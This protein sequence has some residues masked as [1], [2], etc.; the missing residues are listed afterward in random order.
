MR[1][2]DSPDPWALRSPEGFSPNDRSFAHPD[3]DDTS[4]PRGMVLRGQQRAI[5]C[6]ATRA[7]TWRPAPIPGFNVDWK[8]LRPT[9]GSF[10]RD[11]DKTSAPRGM[12]RKGWRGRYTDATAKHMESDPDPRLLYALVGF[13]FN[14]RP[15]FPGHLSTR[16]ALHKAR[17]GEAGYKP[18]R[19]RT[20]GSAMRRPRSASSPLAALIRGGP[21]PVPCR[22]LFLRDRP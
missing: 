4:T 5:E 13:P 15:L 1:L 9:T 6:G 18:G 10:C 16:R 22:P 19:R 12:P 14:V 2:E 3:A 21:F 17:G 20:G 7:S 8:A 11:A